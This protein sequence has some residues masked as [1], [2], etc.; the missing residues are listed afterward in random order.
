MIN[1]DGRRAIDSIPTTLTAFMDETFGYY[2][3]PSAGMILRACSTVLL[4]SA[5]MHGIQTRQVAFAALP[6]MP[7]P[8]VCSFTGAMARWQAHTKAC[9]H[10]ISVM[11]GYVQRVCA[12]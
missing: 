1:T 2:L 8:E 3:Q 7:F 10:L 12:F 6:E 5:A 4:A 9:P 11:Y